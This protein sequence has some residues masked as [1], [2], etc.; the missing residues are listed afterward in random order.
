MNTCNPA[1]LSSLCVVQVVEVD[2]QKVENLKHLRRLV[3]GGSGKYVMFLLQNNRFMAIDRSGAITAAARINS[4]YRIPST[5]SHDL[6]ND[7]S[8]LVE[9]AVPP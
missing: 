4:T 8:T 1:K 9:N 3:E 7:E 6:L 5:M 2:G